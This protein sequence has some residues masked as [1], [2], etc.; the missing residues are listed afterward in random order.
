M[1]HLRPTSFASLA[2]V[3]LA[4]CDEPAAPTDTGVPGTDAPSVDTGVPD[5]SV[6]DAGIDAPEP[7]DAFVP[8]D[9]PEPVD[10]FVP[11]YRI[12]VVG[13]PGGGLGHANFEALLDTWGTVTVMADPTLSATLLASYDIV[14]FG[15]M[16][17][18]LSGPERAALATWT[19]TAGGRMVV[20]SGYNETDRLET[21]SITSCVTIDVD[22]TRTTFPIAATVWASGSQIRGALADAP[23]VNGS[24]VFSDL[25]EGGDREI[26]TTAGD[27]V[28]ARWQ[29]PSPLSG[30]AFVFG[31]EHI[32]LDFEWDADAAAFW[33]AVLTWLV[34]S[35]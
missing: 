19:G 30:R 32:V 4:A 1:R 33:N 5:T 24:Y 14:V 15:D 8:V 11:S 13:S 17:N 35:A 25:H 10:A 9:A 20:L 2:F 6:G 26:V 34:G 7:V 21:Q 3:L 27:T 23:G 12:L 29:G 22:Q 16:S 18:I 28:G 31:D